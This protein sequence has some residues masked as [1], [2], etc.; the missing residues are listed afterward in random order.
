MF[1]SMLQ[2]REIDPGASENNQTIDTVSKNVLMYGCLISALA[3]FSISRDIERKKSQLLFSWVIAFFL[4]IILGFAL[5]NRSLAVAGIDN[6]MAKENALNNL[7]EING[8]SD[9]YTNVPLDALAGI[10]FGIG[11]EKSVVILTSIGAFLAILPILGA[12]IFSYKTIKH[13]Q[14]D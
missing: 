6:I 11:Y 7:S 10:D 13:I 3:I 2:A 9:Q 8:C 1:Q 5:F 12:A 14:D 4:L